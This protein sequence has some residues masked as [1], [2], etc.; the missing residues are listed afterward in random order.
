MFGGRDVLWLDVDCLMMG[1]G[2]LPFD[3][4]GLESRGQRMHG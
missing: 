2:G 3:G 1:C 4:F